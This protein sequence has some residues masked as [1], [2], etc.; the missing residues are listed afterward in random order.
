IR[1]E[2]PCVCLHDLPEGP[3]RDAF[4][5]RET[6]PLP[7]KH[8]VVSLLDERTE[9]SDQAS[10][11]DSRLADDRRELQRPIAQRAP[12]RLAENCKLAL[13]T[14]ERR[15][16]LALGRNTAAD[17][18]RRPERYRLCLS[19]HVDRFELFVDDRVACRAIRRLADDDRSARRCLLEPGCGV[20]DVADSHRLTFC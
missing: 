8:V 3:E 1:L 11:A 15:R 9:L 18:L 12:V 6:S 2:D 10:L 7:P 14:D 16:R 13:A 20:D 5:V 17:T 19:F 4:A